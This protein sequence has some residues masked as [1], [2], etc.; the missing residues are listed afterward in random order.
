MSHKTLFAA[1]LLAAFAGVPGRAA[2]LYRP[3]AGPSEVGT[4]KLDWKDEKRDRDVPVLIY[5]PKDGKGPFPVIVFSHGLGGSREGYA[6]LGKHWASHGYVCVH[7]QHLGSDAAV[8]RGSADPAADLKTAVQTPTN[9]VNRPLDVHFA[10]DQLE[11]LSKDDETF[12]GRLD[13]DRVGMAGHSFGAWTTLAVAGEAFV[14]P[15][16]RETSWADPRVKAAVAMSAAP[17]RDKDQYDKAFA[18]FKVPCLHMTGTLDDSPV[19]DVKAADKRVPFDHI[20]RADQYLITFE[21]GDHMIFSD[22]TGNRGF[23]KLIGKQPGT[24][25]DRSKDE[26]FQ[27]F[28]K[29]TSTAFWDAY[30]KE[31]AKAK[32][33]LTD[34]AC[35]EALGKDTTFEQK[36]GEKK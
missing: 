21:G 4:V 12:K 27:E 2:D 11:K 36:A 30:L 19:G 15:L 13:L 6:Y 1:V 23:T 5:A 29:S 31:D 28:I 24:G 26:H 10:L 14:G 20:T 22:A 8:W 3:D 25:G 9:A 16:G 7:L 32:A 34:G 17:P 35:K 33:L 18:G